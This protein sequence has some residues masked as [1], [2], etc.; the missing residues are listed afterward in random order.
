M[1]NT[2]VV[3]LKDGKSGTQ[4]EY[5]LVKESLSWSTYVA[6]GLRKAT[7]APDN[8]TWLY[9][10]SQLMS[11]NAFLH[12]TI[13][14]GFFLPLLLGGL[15]YV[16]SHHHVV[17]FVFSIPTI[18]KSNIARLFFVAALN[19][20]APWPAKEE[21]TKHVNDPRYLAEIGCIVPCHRSA[22]EIVATVESLL[23]FLKPEHIVVCD[24]GDSPI[25]LDDTKAKLAALD[26]KVVY[27]WIPIGMKT[28]A[29]WVGLN[30]LPDTVKYVMHIDDDTQCPPDMIFDESVWEH[31]KTDGVS[32]GI[33][34]QQSGIVEKL[35]D[36]EF[37]EYSQLRLF[38]SKY[39]T[40]WF[41]HGIIAMWRREAFTDIL[42]QHPFLPFGEDGWIGGINLLRNRQIRQELRCSVVSYAPGTLLPFTGDRTQGYGAANIWKQRSERWFVNAPRRFLIRLWVLF[43]YRHGTIMGNIMFRM[44]ILMHITEIYVHLTMPVS[45]AYWVASPGFDP[46]FLL[47]G[48]C[49]LTCSHW[50]TL[51]M[52]NYIF[53]RHV[54]DIQVD[55]AVCLLTPFYHWFLQL[56]FWF[57]HWR[58]LLYYIPLVPSRFGLY[59]EGTMTPELLRQFH[60]VE[61]MPDNP[62]ADV[63]TD[64]ADFEKENSQQDL[65][66]DFTDAISVSTGDISEKTRFLDPR[67]IKDNS[68]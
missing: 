34:M 44:L 48:F 32:Y 50:S 28:N 46:Y 65:V 17:Q 16:A 62:V 57:G 6:R 31:E 20:M 37:K 18:I 59:T 11:Y 23:K 45:F 60:K 63:E 55:F 56:A 25:P 58:C 26:P 8:P 66:A 21:G 36:L 15:W 3:P 64:K 67:K 9:K 10:S 30:T 68:P 14:Y 35:V 27:L 41:A 13:W 43:F 7:T 24:N 22:A 61:I 12:A 49:I 2:R 51:L 54:P 39:S 29:L 33:V 4:P 38:Q 5:A 53:W 1:P 19:W 40:V 42:K 47:K 52:Q